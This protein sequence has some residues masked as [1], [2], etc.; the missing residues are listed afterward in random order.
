M[1]LTK[2]CYHHERLPRSYIITGELERIGECPVGRGGNADVWFGRYRG[3]PVAIKVLR[4]YAWTD[5]V[6]WEKV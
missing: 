5:I 3:F 4:M 6:D 1:M 2:M